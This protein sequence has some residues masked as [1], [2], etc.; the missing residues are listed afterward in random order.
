MLCGH[1]RSINRWTRCRSAHATETLSAAVA[2]RPPYIPATPASCSE[3]SQQH[4]GNASKQP[5]G[6]STRHPGR[7]ANRAPRA[8]CPRT[9]P[10]TPPAPR[11]SSSRIARLRSCPVVLSK[12]ASSRGAFTSHDRLAAPRSSYVPAR[13][14]GARSAVWIPG[15]WQRETSSSDQSQSSCLKQ[16][17]RT[18]PAPPPVAPDGIQSP[19][20]RARREAR[21]CA[22]TRPVGSRTPSVART[23]PLAAGRPPTHSS[24]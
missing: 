9:G 10:D 6:I 15:L 2:A 23:A 4:A 21:C 1:G 12:L 20:G 17:A 7:L 22:E 11:I 8:V 24:C 3:F 14:P 19:S 16:A 5:V 18:S 13:R